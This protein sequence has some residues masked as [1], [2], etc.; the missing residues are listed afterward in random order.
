MSCSFALQCFLSRDSQS[1][2]PDET[3]R[4]LR[5]QNKELIGALERLYASSRYTD[6]IIKC[7]DRT[8]RVH[9][10]VLCSRSE[11]F[12][13]ACEPGFKEGSSGEILLKTD[14]NDI[15]YDDY[16]LLV[17]YMIDYIYRLDYLPHE[18]VKLSDIRLGKKCRVELNKGQ[19]VEYPYGTTYWDQGV[20]KRAGTPDLID[21][22]VPETAETDPVTHAEMYVMGDYYDL[23]GLKATALMKFKEAATLHWNTP[24]F[25]EAVYIVLTTTIES[26]MGL[27]DIVIETLSKHKE[28]RKEEEFEVL[29]QEHKDIEQAVEDKV[30]KDSIDGYA[31]GSLSHQ[32][33]CGSCGTYFGMFCPVS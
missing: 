18:P 16:P 25:A 2:E 10:A 29:L 33:T 19:I 31:C 7:A 9:K 6:L 17:Q 3:L 1:M 12:S 8:Y 5:E 23:T 14:E 20:R 13:K 27:R 11:F 28:L 32:H 24:R 15:L 21:D 22:T 30:A 26:D 4:L